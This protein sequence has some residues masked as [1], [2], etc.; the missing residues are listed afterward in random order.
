[1]AENFCVIKKTMT[2]FELVSSYPQVFDAAIEQ[3]NKE[4]AQQTN[5]NAIAPFS[6]TG[7]SGCE[8]EGSFNKE[9]D[10]F[11]SVCCRYQAV[12]SP[13]NYSQKTA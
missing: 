11:C 1:M 3:R 12:I 5:D 8:H 6:N 10:E 4:L 7:C 9:W 13:D 2:A